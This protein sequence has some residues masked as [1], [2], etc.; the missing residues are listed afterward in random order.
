MRY[1][2]FALEVSV[3][4]NF[5]NWPPIS[6]GSDKKKERVTRATLP[7]IRVHLHNTS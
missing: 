5:I 4:T 7:A 6:P 3:A 1:Y 2:Y